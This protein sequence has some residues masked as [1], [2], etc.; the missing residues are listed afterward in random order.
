MA[1]QVGIVGAGRSGTRRARELAAYPDVRITAVADPDRLARDAFASAFGCSLSVSDCNRLVLDESVD[2]VLIAS[3]PPTHSAIAL[4]AFE[5]G[6]HVICEAPIA[7]T[8][9]RALEMIKASDDSAGRLFVSLPQ[10]YDPVNKMAL[11]LIENDELGYVY[12]V[13]GSLIKDDYERLNDWH[14]WKGTWDKAGGG[15]MM[16]CGSEIV[17]LYRY[18]IGEIA[19][20]NAICT[21]FAIEP[22]HKAED[23]S[24][25]GIEFMDDISG[26]LA[27]T[28]AARFSAWPPDYAGCGFSVDIYGLEG[29]LR[30]TSPPSKLSVSLSGG[31]KWEVSADE[32]ETDQPTDMLRDFLDCILEDRDPLVTPEHALT[33]LTVLLAGYK[34]S[35]MKRRV[36]LLEEV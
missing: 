11:Q 35:Q 30:I 20:V 14:D 25:L 28:G 18:L 33:A 12:L 31:R 17:D 8:V 3:P 5:V 4:A 21:R 6:K 23:S 22:L 36:E 32:V 19:A 7:T 2:I 1:L 27:I 16:E 15:I 13:T 24:L 34:S 10:R 26:D 29:A 9:G